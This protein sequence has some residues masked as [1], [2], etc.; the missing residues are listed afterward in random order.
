MSSIRYC[1]Q[2]ERYRKHSCC[3]RKIT[4]ISDNPQGYD[5]YCDSCKIVQMK[6]DLEKRDEL[7][8]QAKNLIAF[9]PRSLQKEQWLKEVEG[10]GVK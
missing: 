1:A 4:T 9:L 8:I 2:A 6:D 10:L 3:E 7:L 5:V